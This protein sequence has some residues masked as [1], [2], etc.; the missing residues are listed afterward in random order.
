MILLSMCGRIALLEL[1]DIRFFK[2]LI[3]LFSRRAKFYD[4][5]AVLFFSEIVKECIISKYGNITETNC[6]NLSCSVE[7]TKTAAQNIIHEFVKEKWL[8]SKV[9]GCAKYYFIK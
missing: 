3:A 4:K 1:F 2:S 8:A 9:S 6:L 5:S 7:I